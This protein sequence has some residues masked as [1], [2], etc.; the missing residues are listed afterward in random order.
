[1]GLMSSKLPQKQLSDSLP[2]KMLVL[3]IYIY[4]Y[5]YIHEQSRV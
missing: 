4:I 5:I 3:Y 1:M 2:M